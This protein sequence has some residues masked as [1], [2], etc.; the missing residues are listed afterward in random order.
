MNN[1]V[2]SLRRWH[3]ATLFLACVALASFTSPASAQ[4]LGSAENFAILGA[5]TVT[6]TG[7]STIIGNVGVSP[8][9]EI[10]GFP[11]G[12]IIN[13]GLHAA[14]ATATQAHADFAAAYTA[15][16]GLASPAANDLT[17]SNLG[18]LTLTPGVYHFDSSATSDGILTFD[19]QNNSS[20]RFVIQI[21]TTLITSSSSSVALINGADARNVYFQVGS[22]VTLGSGSTFIGNLLAY[23]SVTAVS[24][25]NLTGRLLALTEAVTLDTN[26]ASS[27]GLTP[28]QLL[29]IST[30][31]NVQTGDNV[32]IGGFIITGNASKKVMARGIGPSLLGLSPVLADPILELHGPDGT[33]MASNDNWKDSQQVEIQNSA[34]A[35]T[36]D[37]ESAIIAT[38]P[39]A[40]YT[41]ILRGKDGTTG[42]GVVEMYDLSVT[43]DSKLANISTRGLVQT[44]NDVMI[45]G[46]IFGNGTASEKV[47]IRAIGPSLTGVAN[48]LADP[49]LALH[50]NNGALLIFDDNWQDDPSQAA[51]IIATGIAP[52]N[53]LE[54][55]IVTTLPPGQYTAIVEGKNGGT[56]V[57]VAEVYHL[58]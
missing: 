10:T 51:Q 30:R 5:S 54:S 32:G 28:A 3:L 25:V 16:A 8:G 1:S 29:N 18:G 46:F 20:A 48:L 42:I 24:G 43:S 9:S 33:L 19:A 47:I 7:T 2:L 11:P 13:G 17:G 15:F 50:D 41:A 22:S 12:I 57:A 56:G 37:M 45:A 38:L 58:P 31:L 6:N 36:N 53:D 55:A 44:G 49:T 27:P 52:H 23:A 4:S 34:L 14:D 26:N 21:G 35:P 39:P 40:N